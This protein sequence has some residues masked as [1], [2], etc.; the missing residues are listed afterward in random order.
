MYE[1]KN[2]VRSTVDW[3]LK[4]VGLRVDLVLSGNCEY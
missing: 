4:R 3:T 1:K 2:M